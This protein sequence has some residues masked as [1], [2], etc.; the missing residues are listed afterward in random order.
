M[1]EVAAAIYPETM[2]ERNAWIAG[3]RPPRKRVGLE[4][5]AGFFHEEEP[6][7]QGKVVPVA[8]VLLANRECPWKC[9]MCDLWQ[10]TTTQK[11]AAGSIPAQIRHALE[12]LPRA[13]VLKLYNSGSFFDRGAIPRED[14]KEIALLARRFERVVVECHP[15][16][17]NRQVLRFQELL[18]PAL[19]VA[20]GL[21]TAHETVL[22]KLNKGFTL[23][24]Y[25]RAAHFLINGGMDLRTFVLVGVPWIA[26]EEQ[27]RWLQRSIERAFDFGSR[28]VSLIPTRTGNGAMEALAREGLFQEPSLE[29]VELGQEYGVRLGRGRVFADLWDLG[30]FQGCRACV[31]GRRHRLGRM[32]LSQRLE[33]AIQCA[34]C[35]GG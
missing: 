8:T 13:Q 15:L 9:V 24:D 18:E 23:G 7:A 4:R 33:P 3:L 34:S 11:A 22:E 14:W 20:M 1:P 6:D 28:I 29:E 26:A 17:V 10:N 16:L 5:P 25:E 21:E 2:G 12:R 27:A 35:H 30:R 19:E 31:E 32:N